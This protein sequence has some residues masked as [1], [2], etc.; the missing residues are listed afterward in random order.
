[1]NSNATE[2]D[3]ESIVVEFN[4]SAAT[5]YTNILRQ[6]LDSIQKI[7]RTKDENVFKMQAA[8]YGYALKS[9]LSELAKQTS[10][11]SQSNLRD[12]IMIALS[13]RVNHYLHEFKLKWNAM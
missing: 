4:N 10:E 11:T 1:M 12:R 7:S 3:I 9:H 13:A 2:K 8:K 5:I 6:F